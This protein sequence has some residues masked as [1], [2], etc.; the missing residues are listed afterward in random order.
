MMRDR[1][2]GDRPY[3]PNANT[4]TGD[5]ILSGALAFMVLLVAVAWVVLARPAWVYRVIEWLG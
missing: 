1:W 2:I 4:T 5:V 3:I